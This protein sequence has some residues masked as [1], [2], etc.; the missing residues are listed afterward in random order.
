[1]VR[2]WESEGVEMLGGSVIELIDEGVIVVMGEVV[3]G[4]EERVGVCAGGQVMAV[5]DVRDR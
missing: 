2:R 4:M 3:G 5:D 1:M